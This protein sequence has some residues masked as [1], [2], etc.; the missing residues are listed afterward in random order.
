MALKPR[1]QQHTICTGYSWQL[2]QS[3]LITAQS[4]DLLDGVDSLTERVRCLACGIVLLPA[5]IETYRPSPPPCLPAKLRC[6]RDSRPPACRGRH[7]KV[8]AH[9]ILADKSSSYSSLYRRSLKL[10]LDWAVH[11]HLWRGQAIYIRSLFE[12]NRN[13]TD[14]RQQRV[15][16]SISP[17]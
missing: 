11:R 10:A 17:E 4:I 2:L 8:S 12:A 6:E 13:I 15:G 14:P 5:P 9:G 1:I 7:C 16:I 3:L